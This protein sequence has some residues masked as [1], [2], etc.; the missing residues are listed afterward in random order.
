MRQRF[1][2]CWGAG[3]LLASGLALFAYSPYLFPRL[4]GADVLA[5]AYTIRYAYV[6]A[7]VRIFGPA[8]SFAEFLLKV[9]LL[10]ALCGLAFALLASLTSRWRYS[11]PARGTP[12]F[13]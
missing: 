2:R 1:F 3:T 11:R 12:P 5:A 13:R 4:W 6:M 8:A 9:A 7:T 10:V